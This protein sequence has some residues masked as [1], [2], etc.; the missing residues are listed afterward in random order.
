MTNGLTLLGFIWGV[1]II[2]M[3][4]HN[5]LVILG[6]QPRKLRGLPGIVFSPWI[7]GGLDHIFFNSIPLFV[8][9]VFM[10]TLGTWS[11]LC[12]TV[13]ITLISGCLLWLLGRNAIHVGASGLIM[14]YMGYVLAETYF[15]QT[16]GSIVIGAVA[17]YY[18]GS[19]LTSVI[20]SDKNVSFEGHFFG[21]ISGI[22]ASYYGCVEPFQYISATIYTML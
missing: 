12:A 8:L 14:G 17:L 3:F 16:A 2:N 19:S 1:Q 15:H 22:F 7:H 11:C 21:L 4:C 9:F 10:L 5:K 18:F 20:P 6:I 13:T